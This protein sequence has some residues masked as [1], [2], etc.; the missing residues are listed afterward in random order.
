M[1]SLLLVLCLTACA[2]P[3]IGMDANALEGLT[4][5]VSPQNVFYSQE[6]Y[7][8]EVGGVTAISG[9]WFLQEGTWGS[10][11]QAFLGRT[12]E[13]VEARLDTYLTAFPT[14][15]AQT[16]GTII[17]DVEHPH[18]KNLHMYSPEDQDAI[19]S[20]YKVR[21]SATKA[22]FPN[23]KLGLYGT[24]NPDGN[25][26]EDEAY[27]AR[28]AALQEAAAEGMFEQLDYM[29]PVIYPRFGCDQDGACDRYY[30]T[31]DE[32]TLQGIEGSQAIT[33]LPI[34][35]LIHHKVA[36]GNSAF[37]DVFLMDLNV[38]DPIGETLGVQLDVFQA[39]GV[40]EAAFWVGNDDLLLYGTNPNNWTV[41]DYTC[42]MN[43][44]EF[45]MPPGARKLLGKEKNKL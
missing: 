19:V 6:T 4:I 44:E 43:G 40:S 35:P 34:L 30:D 18:P 31:Y 23:A 39:E 15:D 13:E 26:E 25:G 24:I 16:N 37:Q 41:P 7:C 17:I 29:V 33:S 14:V 11:F 8:G 28:L 3:E 42:A 12:Q 45:S 38:P 1:R 22:K 32:M 2:M 5:K 9:H 21:I 10:D 27:L 20:A 36:N